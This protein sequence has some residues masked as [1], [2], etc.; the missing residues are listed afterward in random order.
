MRTVREALEGAREETKDVYWALVREKEGGTDEHP[1]GTA[2]AHVYLDNTWR[3]DMSPHKFAG[4]LS[5]L[6]GRG[7][8]RSFDDEFNGVWGLVR[9]D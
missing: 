6:E 9:V 2:W 4:H 3:G 8:Y 7:L 5:A 1:D